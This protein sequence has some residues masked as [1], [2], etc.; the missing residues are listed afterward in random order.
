M[1][2][3]NPLFEFKVKT[4]RMT[5]NKALNRAAGMAARKFAPDSLLKQYAMM[6]AR[7]MLLKDK[8]SRYKSR[9]MAMARRMVK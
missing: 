1:I 5:R 7:C 9:G 4:I 8:I 2:D 3:L 6:R